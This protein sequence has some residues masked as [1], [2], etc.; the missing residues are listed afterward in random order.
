M[1]WNRKRS[2][3]SPSTLQFVV[4]LIIIAIYT[5]IRWAFFNLR[6]TWKGME[7]T[8]LG[9]AAWWAIGE[10]FQRTED[11]DDE[12]H[13]AIDLLEKKLDEVLEN[14][15]R[16]EELIHTEINLER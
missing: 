13:D 12:M 8:L 10:W 6:L 1:E 5:V 16:I 14:Q 9:L 4:F 15:G 11:A 7:E 2:G 3:A